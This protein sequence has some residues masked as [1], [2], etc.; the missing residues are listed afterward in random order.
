MSLQQMH[1]CYGIFSVLL[2]EPEDPSIWRRSC[3]ISTGY[4]FDSGSHSRRP[5]W[6]SSASTT[7]LHST[8]RRTVSR[9]QLALIVVICDQSHPVF[10]LFRALRQTM[11]IA[12]AMLL[13][14]VYGTVFV[15]N[16]F[17][18]T[19]LT[20]SNINWWL[21]CWLSNCWL[22]AFVAL[23]DLTLYKCL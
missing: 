19:R 7:W 18:W 3:A 6:C 15:L 12:V 13:D 2:L 11:V 22:N 17:H 20:H 9:C 10:W 4:W 1:K 21:F 5:F 8:Y 16:C 23:C 14:L